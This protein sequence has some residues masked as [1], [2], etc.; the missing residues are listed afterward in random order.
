MHDG[1]LVKDIA[2]VILNYN[3]FDDTVACVDSI[4]RFTSGVSYRIYIVDNASPD[5]SGELLTAKYKN[6]SNVEILVSEKNKGFSGGN[7]VGI[8]AALKDGYEFVYLLNSDIL[9]ENDAFA[10]MQEHLESDDDIAIVGPSIVDSMGNYTQFARPG[11]TLAL[12]LVCRRFFVTIF[13]KLE[14]KL[15]FYSFNSSEDYVFEGM[16]NGCCF[17]IKADFIREHNCLD[18]NV[19]MYYE[20][21][22]LAHVMKENRKKSYIASKAR[23][24]HNEG[25]ATKKSSSDRML[26][27]RFYRWTSILYV[28]K[29]YAKVNPLICKLIS[30]VNMME[31]HFLSVRNRAYKDKL[32]AFIAENRRVLANKD[33]V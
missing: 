29:N 23:I 2:V 25:V 15:R 33:M 21:D 10:L 22:I 27:T 32:T 14:K 7:N 19:F 30:L 12:Y 4:K 5:K 3:T 28:L 6:E 26:F 31:W 20:E 1:A 9:L 24:I 18:E 17:G 8:R 13:P 11:I 16:V